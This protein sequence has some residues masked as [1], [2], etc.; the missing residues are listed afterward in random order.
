M[1][2]DLRF[3]AEERDLKMFGEEESLGIYR[4]HIFTQSKLI[5]NEHVFSRIT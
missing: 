3:E 1:E 5:N 2:E 4:N